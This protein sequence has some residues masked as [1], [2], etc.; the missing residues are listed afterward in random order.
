[1]VPKSVRLW[2]APF[3][4]SFFLGSPAPFGSE[5]TFAGMLKT[6][7]CHQPLPVGASGSWIETAKLL[8]AAG[9][10]LQLKA[11]EMF[12]PVQPNPLNTCASAMVAPSLMSGLVRVISSAIAVLAP[13]R[14]RPSA[15]QK[16]DFAM[17][18]LPF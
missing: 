17:V 11:G 15:T 9:A 2:I 5:V 18:I 4:V 1:S 13:S 14:P 16:A 10:P 6:T 8:V 12:W 7:Q 3:G